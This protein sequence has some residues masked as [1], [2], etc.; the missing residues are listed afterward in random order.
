MA[1]DKPSSREDLAFAQTARDAGYKVVA[2]D[3]YAESFSE[4]IPGE[5]PIPANPLQFEKGEYRLLETSSGWRHAVLS[6]GNYKEHS[7][8]YEDL[9]GA[10]DALNNKIDL[11]QKLGLVLDEKIKVYERDF[12]R[13]V[14]RT[15]CV[16]GMS[17]TSN[18]NIMLQQD[19]YGY[20]V[21]ERYKAVAGGSKMDLASVAKGDWT[22]AGNSSAAKNARILRKMQGRD[23]A[24]DLSTLENTSAPVVAISCGNDV[25]LCELEFDTSVDCDYIWVVDV[26]PIGGSEFSMTAKMVDDDDF[27][28]QQISEVVLYGINEGV[29]AEI[30]DRDEW[31]LAYTI[32]DPVGYEQARDAHL[33][34]AIEKKLGIEPE[35]E[36]EIQPEANRLKR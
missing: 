8:F 22:V 2:K 26:R 24:L 34:R 27:A 31:D 7:D 17:A 18:K 16:I 35:V 13:E 32:V 33:E 28:A 5:S 14:D 6:D 21:Q 11:R 20:T 29:Y 10:F 25:V 1:V 4:Y 36:P 30:G 23:P 12:K 15:L 9:K 3:N 19:G